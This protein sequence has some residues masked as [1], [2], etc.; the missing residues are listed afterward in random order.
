MIWKLIC[1][2]YEILEMGFAASI[3][4]KHVREAVRARAFIVTT[5]RL[6]LGRY[7]DAHKNYSIRNNQFE[8]VVFLIK[9]FSLF[10]K[11]YF[12]TGKFQSRI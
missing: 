11:G 10:W 4:F 8:S 12:G 5:S 9:L 1:K 6:I 2:S 3:D 7:S